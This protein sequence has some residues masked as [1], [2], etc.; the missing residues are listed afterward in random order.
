MD[1]YPLPSQ[2]ILEQISRHCPESLWIYLQCFNRSD[3]DGNVFFHKKTVEV[4]MS[5]NW[6]KFKNGIKKLAVENLLEWHLVSDGIGVTLA[7][8]DENE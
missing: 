1:L 8:S 5:E 2:Q 7:L 3:N 6:V 4:D